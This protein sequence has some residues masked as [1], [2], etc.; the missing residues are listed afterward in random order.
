VFTGKAFTGSLDSTA[1]SLGKYLSGDDVKKMTDPEALALLNSI[2]EPHRLIHARA[3]DIIE[4][5]NK[6]ENDEAVKKLNDEIFPNTQTVIS[7]LQDIQTRYGE[8]LNDIITEEV[9]TG[10]K[11]EH[12]IIIVIIVGVIISIGLSIFITSNIVKQIVNTANALKIIA[13]GDLTKSINVSS[14]DEVGNLS[15]DINFTV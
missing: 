3:G 4:H 15:R 14:N 1:C 6:G 11:S 12:I 8:L 5:L 13:S 7:N 2:V 9:E 10:V